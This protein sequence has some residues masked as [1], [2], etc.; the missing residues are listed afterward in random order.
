LLPNGGTGESGVIG[1]TTDIHFTT[2]CFTSGTS[3]PVMCAVIL[4][5]E[6]ELEKLLLNVKLGIDILKNIN[7]GC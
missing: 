3:A 6:K 7:T 4:K 2:L 5:S 1:N